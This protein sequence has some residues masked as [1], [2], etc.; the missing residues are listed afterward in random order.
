MAENESSQEKTEEP[1]PKKLREAQKQ[2]QVP[3]SKELNSMAIM[4]LGSLALLSMGPFIISHL[5]EMLTKGFTFTR[6]EIMNPVEVIS[7]FESALW[8]ALSGLLPFLILMTVVALST[9]IML[10]GWAFNVGSMAFKTDKLNPLKGLKRIFSSKGLMELVKALAKFFVVAF[11]SITFM[12]AKSDEFLGLGHEAFLPG[13]SDAAWLLA[14]SFM[15]MSSSLILIAAIDVPFQLWDHS[16]KLKMTL[17]E[18]RDEMK[19]TE[20]RP[21]VKSRVRALQQEMAQRR[22]MED[23]PTADVIITNPTHFAVALKYNPD[24][25]AVPVIVAMGQDHMAFKIRE[26]GSGAGVEIF[27]APPLA[28]ALFAHGKIGQEIPSQLF[29]AVAQVLAFIFQL[30]QAKI[31]GLDIPDRPDPYVPTDE[32]I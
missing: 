18:V 6:S 31:D 15:V 21:E 13:L 1:T 5:T 16:Q 23:V 30:R 14:Y 4:F 7:S 17:Q 11:F 10:G 29:Y 3:R 26:V 27:E 19:E 32:N 12:W 24:D 22:M 20:G 25:M 2:G 28:R 8:I 9:P